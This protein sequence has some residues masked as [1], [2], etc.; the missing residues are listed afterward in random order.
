MVRRIQIPPPPGGVI[1]RM[2]VMGVIGLGGSCSGGS[3]FL[4]PLNFAVRNLAVIFSSVMSRQRATAS[5]EAKVLVRADA[6]FFC[7]S[8]THFWNSSSVTTRTAIGI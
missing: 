2:I 5:F 8:T 6:Y 7:A 4:D 3:H 1:V